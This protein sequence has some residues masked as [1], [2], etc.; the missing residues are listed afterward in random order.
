MAALSN[1][2][3]AGVPLVDSHVHIFKQDMPLIPNPRHAPT[4]GFTAEQL[5]ETLDAHGVKL[6]VI[7]AASPWGDCNDYVVQALRSRPLW[8]GT[9]ILEPT[10]GRAELDELARAGMVGVRLPFIS[11]QELPD[12]TTW[13]YRRFLWRLADMDWHVHLHMDGPRIPQVLPI[14]ENAGVKI[15]IDHLGRP[16]PAL[17]EKCAGFDA[18]VRSVEKG[19]TWVKVS[20]GYRLGPHAAGL[21]RELSRRVGYECLLWASDC[22]FV[23]VEKTTYQSTIDWLAEAVPDRAMWSVLDRNALDLYFRGAPRPA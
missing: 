5:E 6:C 17:K 14:L 10:V 8:R 20:A 19:R 9:A 2:Q 1:T 21:A 15:V 4:Y 12:L 16:D 23:G 13:D 22:P 11:L 3:A 18:V 7:A